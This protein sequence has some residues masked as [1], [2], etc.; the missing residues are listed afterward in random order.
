MTVMLGFLRGP[1]PQAG[2]GLPKLHHVVLQS[3]D[4]LREKGVCVEP[5]MAARVET[6]GW[7]QEGAAA[8][9]RLRLGGTAGK[10]CRAQEAARESTETGKRT[11][12][13]S[14]STEAG[15]VKQS[16]RAGGQGR[17][18][19]S[20]R[21]K[22]DRQLSMATG[23]GHLRVFLRFLPL[24]SRAEGPQRGLGRTQAPG[25]HCALAARAALSQGQCPPS[26]PAL[27]RSLQTGGCG[28]FWKSTK[29]DSQIQTRS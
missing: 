20:L 9:G 8:A 19:S 12:M 16:D 6:C 10:V 24:D 13:Q 22:R 18:G 4:G 3:P 7:G 28:Q 27:P 2:T 5:C 15:A 17:A 21:R 25:A 1:G 23:R 14:T 26:R 29:R 11:E